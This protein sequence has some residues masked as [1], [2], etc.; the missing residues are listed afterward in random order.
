MAKGDGWPKDGLVRPDGAPACGAKKRD[1]TPC[2][3]IPATGN[4]RCRLHGGASPTREMRAL[5]ETAPGP[6][7]GDAT[8]RAVVVAGNVRAADD[9]VLD[10][11]STIAR[12]LSIVNAATPLAMLESTAEEMIAELAATG[13]EFGDKFMEQLRAGLREVQFDRAMALINALHKVG[14][15]QGNA[16]KVDTVRGLLLDSIIPSVAEFARTVATIAERYIPPDR[17]EVYRSEVRSATEQARQRIMEQASAAQG[18]A[19]R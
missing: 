2:M 14:Q 15:V 7:A 4:K 9:E 5:I 18:A 1:G 16:L 19:G 3:M 13:L 12:M 8:M 17:V 11:R 6:L 10:Q